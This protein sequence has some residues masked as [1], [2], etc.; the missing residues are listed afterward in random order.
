MA[1]VVVNEAYKAYLAAYTEAAGAGG[2]KALYQ[3]ATDQNIMVAAALGAFDAKNQ[4]M[5]SSYENFLD[6]LT[7]RFEFLMK[8][9]PPAEE[10][11]AAPA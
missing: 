1:D 11:P 6:D 3:G 7:S 8:D 4:A 5:P 9:I 2:N 10:L